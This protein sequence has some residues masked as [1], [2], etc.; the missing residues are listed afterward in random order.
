M[1]ESSLSDA[2]LVAQVRAGEREAWEILARRHAPRLAAYLG[3]RLR[4]TEVVDNL[5]AEAIFA[6]WR[7]LDGLDDPNDFP[8]WF[9]SVGANLALRWHNKHKGSTG[10]K[11]RFPVERCGQQEDLADSM[12]RVESAMGRLSEQ[13]RMALEQ[14]FRAAL[15]G[16]ALS[17]ALHLDEEDA[18]A[19]VDE[20]LVQLHQHLAELESSEP[21]TGT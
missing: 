15:E 17:E 4:R 10:Q 6:A 3:A 13:H 19:L 20:A 12:Q 7:H 18:E 8:A 11:G 2:D 14:R 1:S 16:A 9:R 5:V 21:A